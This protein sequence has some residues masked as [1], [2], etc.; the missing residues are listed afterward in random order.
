M[1]VICM[2]NAAVSQA[3]RG[4]AVVCPRRRGGGTHPR[5]ASAPNCSSLADARGAGAGGRSSAPTSWSSSGIPR[6]KRST[7]CGAPR[8]IRRSPT[9]APTPSRRWCSPPQHRSRG[10]GTRRADAAGRL[11]V[12][13]PVPSSTASPPPPSTCARRDPWSRRVAAGSCRCGCIRTRRWARTS[14]P[15][16]SFSGTIPVEAVLDLVG[17]PS[18]LCRRR[19]AVALVDHPLTTVLSAAKDGRVSR[20]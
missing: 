3:G 17:S 12:Q 1:A 20:R 18:I 7:A 6:R 13:R 2:L 14:C 19:P 9:C 11:R 8:R 16:L 4:R 5:R 10:C 15:T